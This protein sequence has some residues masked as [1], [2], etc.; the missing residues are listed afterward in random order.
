MTE[1]E[2][3]KSSF[4]G[5]MKGKVAGKWYDLITCDFEDKTIT[6]DDGKDSVIICE[7]IEELEKLEQRTTD[8]IQN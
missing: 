7:C 1:K 4:F 2:F 8:T 5:W 3:N 6:I